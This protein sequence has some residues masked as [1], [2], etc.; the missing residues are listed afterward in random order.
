MEV[1]MEKISEAEYEV[2]KVLWD[3][4]EATSI[5]IIDTVGKSKKWNPNT[6]R[7]LITRLIRKKAIEVVSKE[8]KTYVYTYRVTKQK[9][10]EQEST[11]FLEKIYNGS[12]NSMLV[13]FVKQ[14]KLSKQDI[15]DLMKLIESE[16]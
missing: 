16:E 1:N 15:S 4:Q 2:M 8:G 13:N 11:N 5:D 12:V 6:I 9:Y 3:K 14:N 10:I 7:T